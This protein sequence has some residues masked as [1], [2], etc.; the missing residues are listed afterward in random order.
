MLDTSLLATFR[1]SLFTGRYNLLLGSGVSLT[2]HNRKGEALRDVERLREDLCKLTG[3]KSNTSLTRAY[4]LLTAEQRKTEIVD[5][6]S[7]CRPGADLL[8]LQRYIW[9]RLFTFNV[10]DVIE[11]LYDR[12]SQQRLVSLNFDSAFEPDTDK[13]ELQSI[14]LHG[15]VAQ[16]GGGFVFS[17]TEYARVM[18]SNNPWM[19]LLSELLPAEPFVIAGTSLNEIDLEFYLSGRTSS[20]PR[21]S[22]GPSLL[23]EPFPDAATK[24]DCERYDLTLV[25]A[26]FGDFL[27][28]LSATYP[29]PPSVQGLTVPS[30]EQLFRTRI[31]QRDLLRFFSD[32][33]LVSG[34]T[35]APTNVPSPFL[36]GVEPTWDEIQ[37]HLDIER[38]EN[39]GL[40][41]SMQ[42]WLAAP[43]RDDRL[44]LVSEQPATGKSTLLKRVGHDLAALGTPVFS[45]CTLSRIDSDTARACF[46]QLSAP[47]VLLVDGLADHA[48]QIRDLLDD[49]R[50]DDN[51]LVVAAERRYRRELIDIVFA[52][53]VPRVQPLDWLSDSEV[54][55]LLEQY[56][57][58]G[59]LALPGGAK[60]DSHLVASLRRDQVSVAVCR[61]LNDFRPIDRIVDSIWAAASK[62]QQYVY[63][64]SALAHNCHGTG[65]RYSVLQ[66]VGGPHVHIESMIGPQSPLP[67]AKNPVNDEFLIPQSV[68]IAERLLSRL[69]K[70]N[71]DLLLSAFVGLAEKIAPRVNRYSIKQRTPE[72]RLAGRLFDFDK[73]VTPL[74]AHDAERFYDEV[75]NSWEWN[76]RYWEQRAL[77]ALGRDVRTALQYARHAVFIEKHPHTL[78][79][80][81]KVLLKSGESAGRDER[82]RLF[83]EAF[84]LLNEAID[85]ESQNSRITVHPFSALISGTARYVEQ[86]G[87]LS[88]AQHERISRHL[89]EA[90]QRFRGDPGVIAAVT[91]LDSVL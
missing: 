81:G 90:R 76:S 17:H 12:D 7:G 47:A 2:S 84:N 46:A 75:K 74:L 61:I 30:C 32:F 1:D 80:L 24:A 60:P 36:Y 89:S 50:L 79:T 59:L 52:E 18:R 63:T 73:I 8:P 22:R 68:V 14:H 11:R 77:L 16:P 41:N 38:T 3:S 37:Q 21:K 13:T 28:W 4:S 5:A 72:A 26:T 85:M 6:Y 48:E 91:R 29:T 9:K 70:N 54:R 82:V 10:D 56:Q 58:F 87:Q 39:Q 25:Q 53:S 43:T 66:A 40:T 20:T 65:V 64:V 33:K 86:G 35:T 51:L 49:G 57:R 23:I 71:R 78:T 83:D 15:F 69:S 31:P 67:I 45:V 27:A 42:R 62:D 19:L 55:Q 34:A 88:Q 44:I